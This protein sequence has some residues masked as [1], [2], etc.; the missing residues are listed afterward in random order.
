MKAMTKTLHTVWT[1][2]GA[3]ALLVAAGCQKNSPARPSDVA[4]NGTTADVAAATDAK[5]G[6]TLTTPRPATPAEGELVP[7]A[8]Q[9]MTLVVSNAVTTGRV[10]LTYTFDVA[11]DAGFGSMVFSK[12]GITAGGSQTSVSV[13]K[14][15]GDKTYYWRARATSGG[16]DGPNSKP[17]MLKIGPE[18]V[19]QAPVLSS[20]GANGATSQ[21]PTLTVNNVQR[22]GPAGAIVYRFDVARSAAFN[23]IVY[24]GTQPERGGLGFTSHTVTAQLPEG[25]YWWRAQATDTTNNVTGPLSSASPFRVQSFSLS[26]AIALDSPIDYRNWAE[27][28]HI[29]RLILGPTGISIDFTKRFG[30]GSWPDIIPKNFTGAIQFTLG[31]ALKIDGRWYCSAPIEFWRDR[32]IGGAPP[33]DYAREW[34]YSPARWAPMTFHQPAVGETIGFFVVAGDMR[35]TNATASVR[36]RSN[37]VLVPMPGP[38]GAGF[39][40]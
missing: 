40:F 9:P 36:E 20:P 6:V 16:F 39:S 2:G 10:A 31:M 38:G 21:Q 37:V 11:T 32:A 5:T 8:S 12:G 19:L 27:T 18:V 34:F 35:G 30:A 28:A 7:Y 4:N 17:R 3:L 13:D 33:Q 26:Q 1:I 29:T 25:T 15:P 14:L 22:S 24:S 23:P